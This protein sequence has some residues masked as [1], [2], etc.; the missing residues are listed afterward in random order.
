MVD[1]SVFSI[2]CLKISSLLGLLLLVVDEEEGEEA[3]GLDVKLNLS[4]ESTF[5]LLAVDNG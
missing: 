4:A 2:D 3:V 1:C 5:V